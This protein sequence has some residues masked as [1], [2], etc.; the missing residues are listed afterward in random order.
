MKDNQRHEGPVQE[1]TLTLSN[2]V[3]LHARPAAQFVQRANEFKCNIRVMSHAK[4]VDVNGK[5]ILGILS[6]DAGHGAVITVRAEGEDAQEAIAS[7]VNLFDNNFGEV[8]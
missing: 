3:G 5:S 8:E 7:I 4:G 6:L 1:I 2:R